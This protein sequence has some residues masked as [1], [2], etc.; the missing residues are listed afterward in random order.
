MTLLIGILG[1]AALFALFAF[2]A[3]RDGTRL[4]AGESCQ[5]N[6]DAA[7]SCALQD[8]CDGCDIHAAKG[9]GWWPKD[10]AKD[11]DRR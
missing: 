5:G 9:D 1:G 8:E 11:G 6:P 4:E 10:G 2:T 3:T 7:G